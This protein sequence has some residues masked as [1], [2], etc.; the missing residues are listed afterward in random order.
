MSTRE[1][2][3]LMQARF[4]EIVIK[5]DVS[6]YRIVHSADLSSR[7]SADVS[8]PFAE[9]FSPAVLSPF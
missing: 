3:R 1:L 6:D 5:I 2:T 7:F 9:E 8:N 4:I